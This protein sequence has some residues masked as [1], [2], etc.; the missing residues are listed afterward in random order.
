MRWFQ[1]NNQAIFG[2]TLGRNPRR[3]VKQVSPGPHYG[4]D[5][6]LPCRRPH[7][8]ALPLEVSHGPTVEAS[9]FIPLSGGWT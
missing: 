9:L 6:F 1:H 4:G 8:W 3:E 5:S 2:T 7:L